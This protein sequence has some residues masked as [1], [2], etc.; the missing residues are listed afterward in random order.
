MATLKIRPSAL[1]QILHCAGSIRAQD[2]VEEITAATD[3]K[4]Q[5]RGNYVHSRIY[6]KLGVLASTRLDPNETWEKD[7]GPFVNKI[8][9][10]L[11]RQSLQP[12]ADLLCYRPLSPAQGR[13]RV[14]LDRATGP[15]NGRPSY[16]QLDIS[17]A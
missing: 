14:L 10:A 5:D 4:L 17:Q 15:R 3:K 6:Q 1:P 13:L 8:N 9:D 16:H 2:Q 11:R 7:V 12:T